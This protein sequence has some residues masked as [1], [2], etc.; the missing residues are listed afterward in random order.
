[1]QWTAE[2]R[3]QVL[4][5]IENGA[6]VGDVCRR[7]GISRQAYY[8][9]KKRFEAEGL[10]G[11]EDKS[12]APKNP[13]PRRRSLQKHKMVMKYALLHPALTIMEMAER[14][15]LP[16]STIHHILVD[17]GISTKA[18]RRRYFQ[19]QL[20]KKELNLTREQISFLAEDNPTWLDYEFDWDAHQLNPDITAQLGWFDMN[21]AKILVCI[22]TT[23]GSL[24]FYNAISLEGEDE[25]SDEELISPYQESNYFPLANFGNRLPEGG[26]LILVRDRGLRKRFSEMNLPNYNF[27]LTDE[28]DAF[29]FG[30]LQLFEKW[31]KALRSRGWK[32]LDLQKD[33]ES[34]VS[35]NMIPLRMR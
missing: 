26:T 18:D 17:E 12:R 35:S 34:Y 4:Q 23:S 2:K 7:Y 20:G 32:G 15:R 8:N 1:M 28:A 22:H 31:V 30:M 21:G 11:L 25:Y 3:R 6:R 33:W 29:P 9:W 5:E 10:K 16:K 14:L 24:F 13:Q 27:L 19:K